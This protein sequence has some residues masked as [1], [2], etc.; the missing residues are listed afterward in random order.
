MNLVSKIGITALSTAVVIGC[1]LKT[2]EDTSAYIERTTEAIEEIE[3]EK[4]R[5]VASV[6]GG[7]KMFCIGA[8]HGFRN[9]LVITAAAFPVVMAWMPDETPEITE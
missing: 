5:K 7:I 4:A 6:I 8:Y 1:E 3:D 9:S 2:M